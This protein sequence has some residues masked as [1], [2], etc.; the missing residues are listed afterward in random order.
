MRGESARGACGRGMFPGVGREPMPCAEANGLLPGRG[1]AGREPMP[2]AEANGLL[3]GRGAPGR[4]AADPPGWGGD[5]FSAAGAVGAAGADAAGA[6]AFSSTGAGASAGF[7]GPGLGPGVGALGPGL[8]AP[9]DADAGFA[10]AVAVLTGAAVAGF[11]ASMAARSLRAT[12]GSIVDEGDF[13]NSPSSLSFASANL[14]STP[15]SAAISCTR[16]LPATILLSGSVRPD[17]AD[18]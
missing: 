15:S 3:P 2:C 5:D 12:G 1:P 17:R 16:G 10:A 4:G 13:T 18:H 14:L 11:S 6:A 7:A 8:G 9:E